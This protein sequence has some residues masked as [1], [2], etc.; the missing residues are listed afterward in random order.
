[1]SASILLVDDDADLLRLM[2]IRL[3]AA[4]HDVAAHT[5][6]HAALAQA[7]TRDFDVVVTDLRM[8]GVDGMEVLARIHA[9]TPTVPVI[10]L[11]AH[12]TIPEAVAATR[13]G[14]YGF[15]TKPFDSAQLLDTVGQA[16]AATG[17]G[18]AASAGT[19]AEAT[20]NGAALSTGTAPG[21]AD[22]T[23]GIRTGI[24]TR[25][26][27][28]REVLRRA[29]LAAASEVPV[30]VLGESGTGKELLA[31][32]IHRLSPRTG[33]PFAALNCAALPEALFESELFGHEKGAFTGAQHAHLGV[34][35]GAE[36]G[37]VFLDEIGDMPAALQA[38]FLRVLQDREVRPV[39]G[40][41]AHPIDVRI[42][43][44]THRDLEEALSSGGFREDLYYRLKG[45]VLKLPTLAERRE[46]IVPLAQRFVAELAERGP[47]A[48]T[49]GS[50]PRPVKRLSPEAL[51]LLVAAPWPGN[52]RQL[53]N[54][55]Q[56][57]AVLS[58]GDVIP[59]SVVA[60]AIDGRRESVQ[61]LEIARREF[62]RDY[63][64]RVL[65]LSGGSV[66][67][68]AQLAQRNRQDFYKLMKRHSLEPAMF[69][70]TADAR[71]D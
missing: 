48:A 62:E 13:A 26:P 20:G 42:I 60:L 28:M 6:P 67:R 53:R 16:L 21:E 35:R 36:G 27:M 32:A 57:S 59:A 51:E 19:D 50:E 71:E 68:A 66:A 55:V 17:H 4:G 43:S 39:G 63:L 3:R 56:Q 70:N 23:L 29:A 38:K 69:R 46:D 58:P 1:M 65:R 12:G 64:V 2:T 9:R 44:A 8:P 18:P 24:V 7:S 52:V 41:R 54:V 10:V 15:L 22:D 45:V 14:A 31:R 5:D 37:S 47:G 49:A 34:F 40:L 25:S 30:M 61:P 11:T 33:R